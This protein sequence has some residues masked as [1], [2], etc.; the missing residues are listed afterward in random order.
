MKSFFPNLTIVEPYTSQ[1]CMC[2][3]P[4][5]FS[6]HQQC[7]ELYPDEW[8]VDCWK[9]Y[10]W[11]MSTNSCVIACPSKYSSPDGISCIAD[12]SIMYDFYNIALMCEKSGSSISILH[13][14]ADH[15]ICECQ[16]GWAGDNCEY[17]CDLPCNGEGVCGYSYE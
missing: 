3:D 14:G 6:D 4:V 5:S 10:Y 7:R 9:G 17:W 13:E 11:D 8:I 16:S 15:V 12:Y 1:S 2:T